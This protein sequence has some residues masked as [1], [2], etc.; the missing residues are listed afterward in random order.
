MLSP[1]PK[2][3]SD[4]LSALSPYAIP[5]YQRD[6]TWG[7]EEAEE[8][9][10][11]LTNYQEDLGEKKLGGGKS[12]LFLGNFIFETGKDRKTYIVDGQQRLTTIILLLLACRRK[13]IELG[14]N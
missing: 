13:A 11:D 9:I 12:E 1:N 6:Y 14:M 4:V 7:K 2:S 8:L 5:L 10:D 3:I